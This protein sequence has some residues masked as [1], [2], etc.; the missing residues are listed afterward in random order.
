MKSQ[1][2]FQIGL[3]PAG[4]AGLEDVEFKVDSTGLRFLRDHLAEK[5]TE[6]CLEKVSTYRHNSDVIHRETSEAPGAEDTLR[7]GPAEQ[8]QEEAIK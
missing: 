6:Q 3:G 2:E 5:L 1:R 7:R 8:T 4:G